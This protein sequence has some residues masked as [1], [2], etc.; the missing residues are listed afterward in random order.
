MKLRKAKYYTYYKT[1]YGFVKARLANELAFS[2][3]V[4]LGKNYCESNDYLYLG[5][6]DNEYVNINLVLKE[7]LEN[8]KTVTV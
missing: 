5:T 4:E 8:E 6:F 1:S 3:A 2:E 7:S